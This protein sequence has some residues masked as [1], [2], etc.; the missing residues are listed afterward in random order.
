MCSL[1]MFTLCLYISLSIYLD[2]LCID[3]LTFLFHIEAEE[4]SMRIMLS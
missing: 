1:E 4:S 3:G 2:K